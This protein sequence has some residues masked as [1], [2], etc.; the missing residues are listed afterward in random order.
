MRTGLQE[1]HTASAKRS[2]TW[3]GLRG[4]RMG[5][6]GAAF[7]IAGYVMFVVSDGTVVVGLN[8]GITIVLVIIRIVVAALNQT[9]VEGGRSRS[10]SLVVPF[11][12]TRRT[13]KARGG[14]RRWLGSS[15]TLW[16]A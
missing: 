16:V 11:A 1:P 10:V 8:V 6:G 13:E 5:I 7:G 14:C 9:T 15:L 3:V 12:S 2:R 4:I